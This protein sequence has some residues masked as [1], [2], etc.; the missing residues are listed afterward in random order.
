[1]QWQSLYE[2]ARA[3]QDRAGGYYNTNVQV[4]TDAG[5]V[6]LRIPLDGADSM[7]IRLWDEAD[8]LRT[9]RPYVSHAPRLRHSSEHPR[10]QVQDFIEGRVVNDFAPRGTPVPD[11]VLTDVAGLTAELAR[12][13]R[14]R[15]PALPA[16]W[17][18]D[19]DCPAFGR[20]LAQLTEEVHRT[21][22][23]E[24]GELFKRLDIPDAPLA[25]VDE[26]WDELSSRPYRLVHSDLHR[27]NMIVSS[28]AT[29]FLDWEL[30]LWGDPV[31]EIAVHLHKM[32]YVD[33]QRDEVLRLWQL[34]MPAELTAY[35]QDD[36]QVYLAHERVKSAVV[37]T[38]RYS[39][40]FAAAEGRQERDR[41]ARRL[42]GKLNAARPVWGLPADVTDRGVHS[43]LSSAP[44]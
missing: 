26:R 13:P 12:I 18:A 23:D 43:V 28:G 41:L 5:D 14:E 24:Y 29:F 33:A 35:W 44:C 36:L 25:V 32:D 8:V 1:M 34:R 39:K 38:V 31:Y 21:F 4:R 11:H 10:F 22:H 42:A 7:D 27:K 40:E 30:A 20:R 17:P 3:Q 16:G 19:G 15:V 9:I 2:Q 6:N 37:D